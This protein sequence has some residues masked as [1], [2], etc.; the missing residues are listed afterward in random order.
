VTEELYLTP[1]AVAHRY[2]SLA[3]LLITC[4]QLQMASSLSGFLRYFHYRFNLPHPY[5]SR[6][7]PTF[8]IL[9][10]LLTYSLHVSYFSF[11]DLNPSSH[12]GVSSVLGSGISLFSLS[13]DQIHLLLTLHLAPS[14]PLYSWHMRFGVSPSASP[15]LRSRRHLSRLQ[16]GISPL[17]G[18]ASSPTL[19][20][21]KFQSTVSRPLIFTK[22]QPQ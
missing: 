10:L 11:S 5:L 6:I 1:K 13:P 12:F 14:Y 17:S 7:A 21:T 15:S 19:R 20:L 4:P 2:N 16:C 3:T 22:G 9:H 18:W 8:E